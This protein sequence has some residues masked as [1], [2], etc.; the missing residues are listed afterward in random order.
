MHL[1]MNS[2]VAELGVKELLP[3]YLDPNL[4]THDLLTGI[5]FASGGAGYDPLT[6]RLV[7]VLSLSDQL[8]LFKEYI[9]KLKAAVGEESTSTILSK[10]I[11]IVCA[12][13]DDIANTYYTT[14][15]RRREYDIPSYTDLM[16]IYGLGARRV[17]VFSAPP[18][19][20][21]PSQRTLGGG[22]QRI[23]VERYN[24]AAKLFN[25]KLSSELDFLSNRLPHA[26]L[27]YM[28]IYYPLLSLIQNPSA[29]EFEVVNKGC[30]GS[31][32]IEATILCNEL[33]P[34]TCRDVSKYIFW[35]SYHPTQRA[36]EIL[37][38]QFIQNCI[39]KLFC[40]DSPC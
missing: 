14:P 29:S 37:L 2:P 31:G 9:G 4:Q 33:N 3:A 6:A 25:S 16:E 22:K 36:Y 15:W 8:S 40:P 39:S 32:K 38:P 19:G 1:V 7:S 11:Y 21:V 13:S 34:Y 5:S 17:G 23:C 20:C 35:D 12:G 26:R 28:D 27:V 24:Q 30:C 18:I 10:S